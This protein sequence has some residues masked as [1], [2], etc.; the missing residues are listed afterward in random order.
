MIVLDVIF[1]VHSGYE[2][3]RGRLMTVLAAGKQGICR[4]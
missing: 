1:M 4:N 2:S 3:Y